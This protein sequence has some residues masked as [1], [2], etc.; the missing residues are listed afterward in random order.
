MFSADPIFDNTY[1][2]YRYGWTDENDNLDREFEGDKIDSE[3]D[4]SGG[5][6]KVRHRQVRSFLLSNP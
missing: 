3:P 1:L 6:L 2:G 4:I 5:F